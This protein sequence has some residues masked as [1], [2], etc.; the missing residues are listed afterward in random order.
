MCWSH[1]CWHKHT[2][3]C[4][5]QMVLVWRISQGGAEP[6]MAG[7]AAGGGSVAAEGGAAEGGMLVTVYITP[8]FREMSCMIG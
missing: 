5:T 6:L 8:V 2:R 3:L 4:K 1:S 7:A